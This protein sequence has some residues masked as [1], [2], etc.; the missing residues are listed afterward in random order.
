MTILNLDGAFHPKSVGVVSDFAPADRL[1]A[2]IRDNLR[3]GF[4]GDVV[5]IA[6]GDPAVPVEPARALLAELDRA[7]DLA[8]VSGSST[9]RATLVDR[10]GARGTRAIV[11]ADGDDIDAPTGQAMLKAARPNITRLIGPDSIGLLSPHAGLNASYA[12]LTPPKGDLALIGQ[13]NAVVTAMIDWAGQHALGFSGILGLGGRLDVDTADLLDFFAAD[14]HTR[15]IILHIEDIRAPRKFLSAARAAARAK[16]VIVMKAS[17]PTGATSH[18]GSHASALADQD[19]V[20]DAAFR[21][22]GLIRIG[23]LDD[24]LDAATTLARVRPFQGDGLAILTNTGGCARL[25][26][27]RLDALGGHLAET[28][29]AETGGIV[30]LGPHAAPAAYA[31]SLVNLLSDSGIDAVLVINAPSALVSETRIAET[32]VDTADELRGRVWPAKP[33]FASWMGGASAEEGRGVLQNGGIPTF[34]TPGDAVRGFMHLVGYRKGIDRLMRIPE[35]WPDHFKPDTEAARAIVSTALD[36]GQEWLGAL[37]AT[38]LMRAYDIPIADCR[39]AATAQA[40][41]EAAT[42]LLADHEAVV[43]KIAG[44]AARYKT[45]IGGVRL[46]LKTAEEAESAAERLLETGRAHHGAGINGVT[47]HPMVRRPRARELMLGLTDDPLFGPTMVFGQGGLAVELVRDKTVALP[48]LDMALAEDM[49]AETRVARQLAAFRGAPPAD[50]DAVALTLVKLSQL[51][52]D[53][54]A[55]REVDLNPVLADVDGVLALDVRVRIAAEARAGRHGVNPRFAIRPYPTSWERR[56]TLKDDR[57]V[58]ARPVRPEDERLYE[59]FFTHVT[60]EDMRLRFFTPSPN[61]SHAFLA[62][63]T[64][65]DYGRAMAF[66]ALDPETGGLLGVVRIHA[67]ADHTRGEYAILLR[68]TLKGLGLGWALMQLIIDYA[69]ADGLDEIHGEVLAENRTMLAMCRDLGFAVVRDHDD[70]AV[71]HVSFDLT[72]A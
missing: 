51:A 38:A 23:D 7:P 13:S 41:A 56:L 10:L 2:V 22:S 53:L 36:T 66:V 29:T 35:S 30:D 15:A 54:P 59:E 60:R 14:I 42:A 40:A 65:I 8:V 71:T 58:L 55:V 17:S 5:E 33:I 19:A 26:A 25:T 39:F 47:V 46:N 67:D 48:P 32:V 63:L 70:P 12:H 9:D 4:Q 16:P 18:R 1:T 61:L 62:R 50:T 24:M 6:T 37:D 20:Y 28:E 43:V 52:A 27:D 45:D 57:E 49:I 11:F 64:Q 3:H 69:R 31:K 34:P 21:R 72:K 44:P 68:S